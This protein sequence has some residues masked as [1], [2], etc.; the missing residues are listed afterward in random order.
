MQWVKHVVRC[1]YLQAFITQGLRCKQMLH[2]G[3]DSRPVALEFRSRAGVFCL[4]G[5]KFNSS[6]EEFESSLTSQPNRSGSQ[7]LMH[8]SLYFCVKI[9]TILK[10]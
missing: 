8:S 2:L 6:A 4:H 1:F 10:A 7:D 3:D 5:H 9:V